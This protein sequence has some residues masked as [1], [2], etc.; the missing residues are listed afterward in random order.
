MKVK[1][2]LL[3]LFSFMWLASAQVGIETE[4]PQSELDVNGDLSIRKEL[5]LDGNSTS[6]GDP[7]ESGQVLFSQ[8]GSQKPIWKSVNVPFLEEGQIQLK[9]S[10]AAVDDV[11]ILFPPGTGDLVDLSSLGEPLNSNWTLIPALE[12][13][14]EVKKTKNKISMFFQTGVE[15]PNTYNPESSN[16]YF[17]RYVCGLFMDDVLVA[18]R[19]DQIKGI[20]NKNAKNQSLYTLAYVLSD[21]EVGTHTFK[22]GCRKV[23]TSSGENYPLA[24]GRTLNTGSDIANNFMLGSNMKI[25]VMEY[26]FNN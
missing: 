19:G 14:I 3:K 7:G 20:N 16:V 26:I 23:R 22:V 2:F 5:R 6:L 12:S 13:E 8:D 18:V 9:Y 21:V 4:F 10:V 1:I 17:V 11:G 25:D 24:I 15:M